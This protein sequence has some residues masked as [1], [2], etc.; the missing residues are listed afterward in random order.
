MI[1]NLNRIGYRG[2]ISSRPFLGERVAQ[3]VQNI[4][5]G[6]YARRRELQYL[7][8]ATEYAIPGSFM[9]LEKLM[10]ELDDLKGVIC[11]SLF[12]LPDKP[13]E[14]KLIYSLLIGAG[15]TMHFAAEGLI[16]ESEKDI[17]KLESIWLMRSILPYC[18]QELREWR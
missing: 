7:L 14:R 17:A 8:S 10:K 18:P 6:D 11:Y 4:V 9:M 5:I 1:T 15:A 3:H 12:M 2:Y 16:F 13:T